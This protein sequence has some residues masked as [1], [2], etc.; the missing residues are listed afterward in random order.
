MKAVAMSEQA[1]KVFDANGMIAGRLGATV[2][3]AALK[4]ERVV[5]VNVE[6]AV[7][8]GDRKSVINA[9]K[10]RRKIKTSTKPEKGPLH[11]KR[12]D[13]MF[14]RMIRGMLP[15]PT[16]RAMDAYRRIHVFLGVPTEY[17]EAEKIV[18]EK[19]RYKSPRRKYVTI[20]DLSHEL[21]W[22]SLEVP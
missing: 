1:V 20:G 10:V 19:S 18:L 7:I 3:K 9:Y 15:W 14:R 22:R 2:A 13:K 6:K 4:G 5:I 12:P 8:T 16:S 21:G 11:Q 17:A